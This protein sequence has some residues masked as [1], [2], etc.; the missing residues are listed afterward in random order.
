MFPPLRLIVSSVCVFTE[1]VEEFNPEETISQYV[2]YVGNLI[3]VGLL[4]EQD[5]PLLMHCILN[6]YEVVSKL[7]ALCVCVCVWVSE[8]LSEWVSEWFHIGGI[9]SD[10]LL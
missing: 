1:E 4:I 5:S 8:W 10:I 7:L 3:E 2:E 9:L 6:F